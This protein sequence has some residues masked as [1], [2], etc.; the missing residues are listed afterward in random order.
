MTPDTRA[1]HVTTCVA[2]PQEYNVENMVIYSVAD[3]GKYFS[4]EKGNG[5]KPRPSPYEA[6]NP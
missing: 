4:T 3:S 1:L 5:D 6:F 2:F